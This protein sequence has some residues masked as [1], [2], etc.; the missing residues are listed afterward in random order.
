MS[1]R[2][3][4]PIVGTVIGAFFGCPQIGYAM[5]V[6]IVGEPIDPEREPPK[7]EPPFELEKPEW[8]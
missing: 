2:V 5:G 6:T 7:E 3:V 8:P 1:A 4:L